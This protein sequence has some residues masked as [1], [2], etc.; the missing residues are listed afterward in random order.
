MRKFKPIL[1]L[2]TVAS[3]FALVFAL[4]G[5]AGETE[6]PDSGY[7]INVACSENLPA[8]ISVQLVGT[9]GVVKSERPLY[10]G[11]ATFTIETDD[12]YIVNL[13][14]V[15]ETYDFQF[16]TVSPLSKTANI[17]LTQSKVANGKTFY[18]VA[19]FVLNENGIEVKIDPYSAQMCSSNSCF[20]SVT[21]EESS[22]LYFS[23]YSDEYH[24][25]MNVDGYS[26]VNAYYTISANCR[27]AI[28]VLK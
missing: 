23:L 24:C 22:R 13:L 4:V 20:L 19:V 1:I 6:Q 12:S 5:C 21:E 10:N 11:K 9:D 14:G 26:E 8:G 2:I 17:E 18:S 7:V 15:P 27:Y 16:E 28:V 3:L 25:L